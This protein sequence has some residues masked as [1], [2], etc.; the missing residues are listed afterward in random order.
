MKVQWQVNCEKIVI[1]P[2]SKIA[3]VD[4]GRHTWVPYDVA[5]EIISAD[6]RGPYVDLRTSPNRIDD[7]LE[8]KKAIKAGATIA[9]GVGHALKRLLQAINCKTQSLCSTGCGSEANHPTS[10]PHIIK[11]YIQVATSPLEKSARQHILSIAE[12][13]RQQLLHASSGAAFELAIGT[14]AYDAFTYRTLEINILA[15]HRIGRQAFRQHEHALDEIA[16]A[17]PRLGA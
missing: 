1:N 15:S 13:L 9:M 3:I 5:G 11:T 8:V 4:G 17:V 10:N 16:D 7:I 12:K 14:I 6:K 2:G